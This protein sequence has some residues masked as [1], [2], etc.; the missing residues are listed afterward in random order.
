MAFYQ[1][2]QTNTKIGFSSELRLQIWLLEELYSHERPNLLH[3]LNWQQNIPK[4]HYCALMMPKNELVPSY[5]KEIVDDEYK[6]MRELYNLL[7]IMA[8]QKKH[9]LRIKQWLVPGL[10]L[11]QCET[12]IFQNGL[13]F[14]F[15]VW[16]TR[17]SHLTFVFRMYD[18]ETPPS[19]HYEKDREYNVQFSGSNHL[20]RQRIGSLKC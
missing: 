2:Q 18:V 8:V 11:P 12:S 17:I 15:F 16:W 13:Y 9:R 14:H 4:I 3:S 10:V 7:S 6:N 1:D 19:Q 5:C 20:S